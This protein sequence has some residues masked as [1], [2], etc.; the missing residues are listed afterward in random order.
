MRFWL[1]ALDL[2]IDY[3]SKD[4]RAIDVYG[5]VSVLVYSLNHC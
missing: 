5:L 2:A 3:I 1:E 4:K